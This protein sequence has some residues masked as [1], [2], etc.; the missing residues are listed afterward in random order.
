MKNPLMLCE[1][2]VECSVASDPAVQAMGR[3]PY[4][5]RSATGDS[6]SSG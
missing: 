4:A 6:D 5:F 1:Q 3:R 2:L